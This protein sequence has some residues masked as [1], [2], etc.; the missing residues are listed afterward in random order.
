MSVSIRGL[1]ALL[2]RAAHDRATGPRGRRARGDRPGR[3]VGL[4]QVD[5]AGVDLRP[6]RAGRR[7]DRGRRRFRRPA[8][9]SPTAP[10][11][12]SATSCSPGTRRSTTRRWRC[13]TA[14][15]GKAAARRAGGR[16]VRALRP[17]RL[18]AGC[19][20]R[21]LGRDAPARRLPPHPGRRQA[22]AGPRRALRRA[23]RDHP[24]GDAG[25][26]GGGAAAR[27][28]APSS[29][30]P[31]TSRRRSTSADRVV[32]LSTRP[33]RVVDRARGAGARA[34]PTATRPS[35]TPGSSPSASGPCTPSANPRPLFLS[36]DMSGKRNSGTMRRWLL[37]ALLLAALL[38][39][40]QLA[41]SS[42]ALADVLGL[43]ELPRPLARGNRRLAVGE[44]L[45]AR[46][47]RLGDPARDPPRLRLRA[48]SPASAFA[49]ADAPLGHG[50]RRRLS[51]DRRLADDPDHRHRADPGGL[52]RLRDRP[53]AR[54]SWR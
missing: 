9:A 44:P 14:A 31:T 48:R 17:R 19:A 37:P 47:K 7:R 32:V 25:V 26:A 45:A 10:T 13:A 12:P 1:G 18:R 49:V 8:S 15:L 41:A 46:R 20:G 30:S 54:R 42:G 27:T 22:A 53:E 40:W 2:R 43:E 33:A 28:R 36:H 50:P 23:R 52:V 34:R 5:A 3:A 51:A 16:A 21:A 11:C 35:P 38:G 6:A 39:A 29:S 24:G 4:R